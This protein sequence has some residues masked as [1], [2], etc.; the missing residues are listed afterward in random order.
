M[1]PKLSRQV[2]LMVV[3]AAATS[4]LGAA[5]TRAGPP[6][7]HF[8]DINNDQALVVQKP[9]DQTVAQDLQAAGETYRRSRGQDRGR[10]AAGQAT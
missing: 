4:A 10:R 5:I 2:A 9:H 8:T 7:Y 3:V 1:T 6:G